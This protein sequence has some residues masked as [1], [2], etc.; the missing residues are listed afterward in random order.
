MPKVIKTGEL[1][2]QDSTIPINHI[3]IDNFCINQGD[4]E[5]KGQEVAKQQQYYSQASATLIAIDGKIGKKKE[6]IISLPSILLNK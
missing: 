5:E 6:V 2:N 1:I 3:W 4:K